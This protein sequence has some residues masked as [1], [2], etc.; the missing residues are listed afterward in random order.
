MFAHRVRTRRARPLFPFGVV[1]PEV[2]PIRDL[3]ER[4]VQGDL[5]GYGPVRVVVTA[6]QWR[7]AQDVGPDDAVDVIASVGEQHAPEPL[8]SPQGGRVQRV[9]K[10]LR[11]RARA[12]DHCRPGVSEHDM[13]VLVERFD[14]PLEQVAGVEVVVGGPLEQLPPGLPD[15]EV[16]VRGEADVPRLPDKADP[17]VLLRVATADVDGAVGRGVVRNDQLEV[18]VALAE[19]GIERLGEVVLA[20]VNREARCSAGVPHSSLIL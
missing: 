4:A 11:Y 5:G 17:G 16:V 10:L 3:V 12:I 6:V 7:P 8:R 1:A 14:A 2:Q 13:R 15:D 19:Q 18:L 9:L 20:V